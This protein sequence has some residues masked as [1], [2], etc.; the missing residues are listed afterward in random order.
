M[1]AELTSVCLRED[2]RVP[3]AS[4]EIQC[5]CRNISMFNVYDRNLQL[6]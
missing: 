3:I 1:K 2:E 4:I 5:H 6:R